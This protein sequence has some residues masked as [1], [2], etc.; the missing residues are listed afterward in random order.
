MLDI[1]E[2]FVREN[3]DSLPI[4]EH[5]GVFTRGDTAAILFLEIPMDTSRPYEMNEISDMWRNA[6]GEIP[7][8][9]DLKFESARHI[10]GGPPLSFRL[11]GSNY[12]M[13]ENAAAELALELEN[14]E[15]V[16]DIVNSASAGGDEIKQAYRSLA[17]RYH[18]DRNPDDPAAEED[19]TRFAK[20]AGHEVVLVEHDGDELRVLLRRGR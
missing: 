17:M 5:L 10:G 3:P 2:R 16:F 13:L 18:P 11:S 4:I 15:G 12:E 8:M 7:G 19:L 20:R 9:K 6:V 14:Y 1:N